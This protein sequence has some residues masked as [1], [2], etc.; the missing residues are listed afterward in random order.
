MENPDGSVGELT[1][2]NESGTQ[3]LTQ[4]GQTVSVSGASEITGNPETMDDMEIYSNFGTVIEIQPLQPTK[5]L[6]YFFFDSSRM[7]KKSEQKIPLVVGTAKER[8]SMDISVN[9]HTDRAGDENYNYLL[10]VRRAKQVEKALIKSGIEP[11]YISTTSH[12]E[13]NP[14]IPTADNVPEPKNRRVEVIVR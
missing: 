7:H 12:G 14:L 9:G 11:D 8:E 3:V 13:G 5:I 2:T 6:L 4:A 1:I 10:S